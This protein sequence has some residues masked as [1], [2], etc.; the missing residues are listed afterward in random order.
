MSHQGADD[1]IAARQPAPPHPEWRPADPAQH[2]QRRLGAVCRRTSES[3]ANKLC[4]FEPQASPG[5]R[6]QPFGWR[7]AQTPHL[8]AEHC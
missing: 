8:D 7:C 4:E 6:D 1:T 2:Q 3:L 5:S